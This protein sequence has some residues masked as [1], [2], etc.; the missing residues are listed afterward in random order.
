MKHLPPL[1]SQSIDYPNPPDLMEA[2][3]IMGYMQQLQLLHIPYIPLLRSSACHGE[4]SLHR[5]LTF[6][7]CLKNHAKI[8]FRQLVELRAVN[9]RGRWEWN[10]QQ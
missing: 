3:E 6:H 4:R 1:H 5:Y 2:Q 9:L 8:T 7:T 10:P